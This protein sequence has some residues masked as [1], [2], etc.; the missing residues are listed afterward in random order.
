LPY[1]LAWGRGERMLGLNVP[2]QRAVVLVFPDFSVN[3]AEAYGWLDEWRVHPPPGAA[4][5]VSVLNPFTLSDWDEISGVAVNDFQEVVA[6]RHP[7]VRSVSHAL[8]ELGCVISM[9]SGSGSSMFGI[10]GPGPVAETA[11]RGITPASL[12]QSSLR[13]LDVALRV[14]HTATAS[15]VEPVLPIE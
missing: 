4:E 6:R 1:A 7:A 8:N 13:E 2:R 3:T 14:V 5:P 12:A 15:R 10:S 9:M 11:V